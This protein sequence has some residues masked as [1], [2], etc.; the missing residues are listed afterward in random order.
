MMANVRAFLLISLV[1][2]PMLGAMYAAPLI[3]ARHI[4][5]RL[6]L[7][8]AALVCTSWLGW[9]VVNQDPSSLRQP[10]GDI[11]LV[12]GLLLGW[13]S[14]PA[15]LVDRASAVSPV[16]PIWKRVAYSVGGMYVGTV[17]TILLGILVVVVVALVRRF[18]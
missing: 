16:P 6:G 2:L 12:A 14:A 18:A 5:G 11:A 7:W 17:I 9:A 3:L 13:G 1:V 10:V 4:G 8:A 15:Y